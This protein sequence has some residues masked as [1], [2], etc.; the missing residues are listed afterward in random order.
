MRYKNLGNDF[1]CFYEAT[2]EFKTEDIEFAEDLF[3]GKPVAYYVLK[4]SDSEKTRFWT[5][6]YIE[7]CINDVDDYDVDYG[8][9][10]K[11]KEE[12]SIIVSAIRDWMDKIE[13]KK[14]NIDDILELKGMPYFEL[15]KRSF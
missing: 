15:F 3:H 1:C 5:P 4:Y 13:Q 7:M 8:Y 10:A 11:S 2:I 12:C 14:N 6:F 9:I